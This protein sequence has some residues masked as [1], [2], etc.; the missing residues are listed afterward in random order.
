MN[1][2]GNAQLLGS[3][4]PIQLTNGDPGQLSAA[5]YPTAL[6]TGGDL[7]F[8]FSYYAQGTGIWADGFTFAMQNAGNNAIG[9]LG[10]NLGIHGIAG[11]FAYVG[12]DY[13][14]YLQDWSLGDTKDSIRI[15][16]SD[17]SWWVHV[18]SQSNVTPNIWTGT[19]YVWV[20]YAAG[21]HTMSM[22]YSDTAGKPGSP[23]LSGTVNL[24]A[25]LGSDMYVGFT[26]A[27]YSAG[28]VQDI[29]EF[30]MS[31]EPA[32]GVLA[33]AGLLAAAILRRRLR[34]QDK[35]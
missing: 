5:W 31:P 20:D 26:G 1:L 28:A 33:I 24:A 7:H 21:T 11:S 9:A 25:L 6:E 27:S 18:A 34:S 13:Y 12:F 4:G 30:D 35:P 14:G 19:R 23:F 2:V 17:V 8:S 10:G 15:Q 16:T 29:L 3:G 22:Y 32:T